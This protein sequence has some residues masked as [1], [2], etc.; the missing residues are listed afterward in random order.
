VLAVQAGEQEADQVTGGLVGPMGVLDNEDGRFGLADTAQGAEN[1]G[2]Q[3]APVVAHLVGGGS[4][5]HDT[6]LRQ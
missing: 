2:E 6:T 1:G 3:L 5:A 4:G